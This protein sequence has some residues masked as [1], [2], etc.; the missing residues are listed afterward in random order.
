MR[1]A[2]QDIMGIP[3][4]EDSVQLA[5]AVVMQIPV[6]C[7]Q[8]NVSAQPRESKETSVNS[9]TLK[10]GILEIHLGEHATTAF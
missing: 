5:H 10:I 7:K 9:V 3:Q 2:C 4:T 8:E 6:T 1:P